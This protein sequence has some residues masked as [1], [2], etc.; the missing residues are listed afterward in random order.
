MKHISTILLLLTVTLAYG[1]YT[2]D[3]TIKNHLFLRKVYPEFNDNKCSLSNSY[4]E[5]QDLHHLNCSDPMH[6]TSMF[7]GASIECYLLQEQLKDTLRQQFTDSEL[8]DIVRFSRIPF[9]RIAAFEL[10]TQTDYPKDKVINFLKR[11]KVSMFQMYDLIRLKDSIPEKYLPMPNSLQPGEHI[12]RLKMLDIIDPSAKRM[13]MK[14]TL[15]SYRMIEVPKYSNCQPLDLETYISLSA[16]LNNYCI[17]SFGCTTFGSISPSFTLSHPN[18]NFG[19]INLGCIDNTSGQFT[20]IGY[21]KVT[22]SSDKTIYISPQASSLTKF[23]KSTYTI[24][25]KKE[26]LIEFSSSVDLEHLEPSIERSIT[27]KNS[28]TGEVLDFTFNAQFINK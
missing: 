26:T 21:I 6:Q 1:Q 13:V 9:Y 27:L 23:L 12:I 14:D 8:F 15:N 22:N 3:E 4:Y 5:P 19:E 10:Y 16:Y 20:L 24:N 7:N 28:K 17:E 2:L 18:Y 11:G 25:P